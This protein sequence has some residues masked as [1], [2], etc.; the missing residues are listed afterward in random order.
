MEETNHTLT[1]VLEA[2]GY[3]VTTHPITEG[4]IIC[5]ATREDGTHQEVAAASVEEGLKQLAQN[6]GMGLP[7][8][9]PGK[10]SA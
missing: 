10:P 3:R 6:V 9:G 7:V 5:R 1:K 4:V 2:A 8:S